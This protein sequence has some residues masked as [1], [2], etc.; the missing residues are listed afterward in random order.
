MLTI[1]YRTFRRAHLQPADG[2][3]NYASHE[4]IH[5]PFDLVSQEIDDDNR[6]VV[7]AHRGEGNVMFGPIVPQDEPNSTPRPII[8]VMNESGATV[9]R[10]DL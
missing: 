9:A 5:G 4:Q 2:P 8:W 10:Y 1:K 3:V 6:V 7:F